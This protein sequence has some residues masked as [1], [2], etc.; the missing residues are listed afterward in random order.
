[1]KWLGC[2][3]VMLG[4][5]GCAR[6][7]RDI[8]PQVEPERVEQAQL[9]QQITA[10]ARTPRRY[11]WPIFAHFPGL[12]S[13]HLSVPEAQGLYE[14]V[15]EFQLMLGIRATGAEPRV[16]GLMY[17]NPPRHTLG[18]SLSEERHRYTITTNLEAQD[19]KVREYR[20]YPDS[21]N[22]NGTSEAILIKS[23]E[24]L[25]QLGERLLLRINAS[26]YGHEGREWS[27][28][29]VNWRDTVPRYPINGRTLI[30]QRGVIYEVKSLLDLPIVDEFRPTLHVSFEDHSG[31]VT[32]FE[33]KDCLVSMSEPKHDEL[34]CR[35]IANE[36]LQAHAEVLPRNTRITGPGEFAWV[37]RHVLDGGSTHPDVSVIRGFKFNTTAG[38][39]WVTVDATSGKVSYDSQYLR[40]KLNEHR[41]G[42]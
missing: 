39:L 18:F 37:Q 23:K 17:A 22:P 3:V 2:V 8:E 6:Q 40:A 14:A 12:T 26:R 4:V 1:M 9:G 30:E 25:F 36:Y 29:Q 7:A 5:A 24:E 10:P 42:R 34:Y 15:Q 11:N 21:G 19:A 27:I 31:T 35:K 32:Q 16:S 33:Y 13:R 20:H 41:Y 38:G 28:R